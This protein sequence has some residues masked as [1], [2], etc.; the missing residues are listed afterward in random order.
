M[1]AAQLLVLLALLVAPLAAE[2]QQAG[3]VPRIGVLNIAPRSGPFFQAFD[4]RLRALGYVEGQNVAIEFRTAEGKVEKLASLATELVGRKVDVIVTPTEPAARAVKEATS[5]IPIVMAGINYDP[6]ALGYVA[7]LAR[8]GG[9]VTGIFF[10]HIELTAKRL[11]L[12]KEMVPTVKRVAI[13]SDPL[14]IDQ[15]RAVEAANTRIQFRLQPQ[16][17]RDSPYDFR[18]AFSIA[19]RSHAEAIFVLESSPIFRQRMQITQLALKNRL[20]TSFAFREYVEAGGLMAYGASFV[21]MAGLAAVYVDKILKG[22]KP[23]DLPMEQPTKFELVINLKT[24]K[25][26]GLTIPPSLLLRA[27]QVIE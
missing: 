17:L 16:D 23:A 15:L 3:K 24:A 2:G 5:T 8:P 4:Q 26:L 18:S 19:M 27:D 22:A 9:N 21:E 25:A 11:E 14:T 6:I 10:R 20:P 7:T 12:F 1:I 13:F